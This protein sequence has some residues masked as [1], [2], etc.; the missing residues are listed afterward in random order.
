MLFI[1][2]W[3]CLWLL[4]VPDS[5]IKV[6]KYFIIYRWRAE[7]SWVGDDREGIRQSGTTGPSL[8]PCARPCHAGTSLS[9]T[10]RSHKQHS[11]VWPWNEFFLFEMTVLSCSLIT[12]WKILIIFLICFPTSLFFTITF[13]GVTLRQIGRC[14]NPETILFVCANA[15]FN[16]VRIKIEMKSSLAQDE[17]STST[18]F[19]WLEWYLV[20]GKKKKKRKEL[21]LEIK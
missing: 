4:K 19:K 8:L 18:S 14:N 15:G 12:F 20:L 17:E 2:R 10:R 3:K 6:Y 16:P 9:S 1:W 7:A 5:L 13:F 21:V 11:V